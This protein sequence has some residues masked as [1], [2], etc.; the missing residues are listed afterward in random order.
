MQYLM[1]VGRKRGR[2]NAWDEREARESLVHSPRI[3]FNPCGWHGPGSIHHDDN[4]ELASGSP[5]Y[6]LLWNASGGKKEEQRDF[7]CNEKVLLVFMKKDFLF[8]HWKKYS[9]EKSPHL[10]RQ[11][12]ES[13]D[14]ISHLHWHLFQSLWLVGDKRRGSG[15]KGRGIS[16]IRHSRIHCPCYLSSSWLISSL[17]SMY[18]KWHW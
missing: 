10:E 8:Y 11:G 18:K 17:S 1:A 6:S 7:F 16:H 14:F 15:Y 5:P 12:T 3:S 13:F 9:M 4:W 2:M